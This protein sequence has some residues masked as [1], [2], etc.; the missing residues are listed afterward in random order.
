MKVSNDRLLLPLAPSMHE[1]LTALKD[2][3]FSCDNDTITSGNDQHRPAHEKSESLATLMCVLSDQAEKDGFKL[4][5]INTEPKRVIMA[6]NRQGKSPNAAAANS[7]SENGAL[8]DTQSPSAESPMSPK[9]HSRLGTSIR[10]QCRMRVNINF[11][12][13]LNAWRITSFE[14]SHNHSYGTFSL[15]NNEPQSTQRRTSVDYSYEISESTIQ[16]AIQRYRQ[17]NAPTLDMT[18]IARESDA[19]FVLAGMSKSPAA[20]KSMRLPLQPHGHPQQQQKQQL[21]S[22]QQVPPSQHNSNGSPNLLMHQQPLSAMPQTHRT[23]VSSSSSAGLDHRV[24]S[25]AGLVQKH[26]AHPV[27]QHHNPA[28]YTR[29][30]SFSVATPQRNM[31]QPLSAGQH[32][33][34][35]NGA[36]SNAPPPQHP[37]Q[38][39]GARVKNMAAMAIEVERY[40]MMHNQ[41]KKVIAL[42]C[43]KR[44][45]TEE[46]I[47]GIGRMLERLQAPEFFDGHRKSITQL[48]SPPNSA[49]QVQQQQLA[50]RQEMQ[51]GVPLKRQSIHIQTTSSVNDGIDYAS[52]K[53]RLSPLSEQNPEVL[54]QQSK[55]SQQMSPVKEY[56]EQLQ[57]HLQ[58]QQMEQQNNASIKLAPLKNL[59]PGGQPADLQQQNVMERVRTGEHAV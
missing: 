19:A 52:K 25:S 53:Q 11:H 9:R 2:L 6:C 3:P 1:L 5:T 26:L 12:T 4:I 30:R 41:F 54:R 15:E 23:S 59:S 47:S 49:Q 33:A 7:K 43:K 58:S 24:P 17:M 16:R 28:G 10:C 56:D 8:S 37:Q 13:K 34:Y 39:E 29:R 20:E 50:Q 35:T 46:V 21:Q 42:A 31:A 18:R 45:S 48:V 57:Q 40:A 32:Y 51:Y 36:P 55:N 14:S 22:F 44:D 38:G 27:S